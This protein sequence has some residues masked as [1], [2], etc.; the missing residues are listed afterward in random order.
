MRLLFWV[1]CIG[2]LFSSC[3]PDNVPQGLKATPNAVGDLNQLVII[4][5]EDVW[6]G[7]VGD[8]LR[9]YYTSAFPILPQ[10]EP[11]F[12]VLHFTALELQ[13]E[14]LRKELRN[15]LVVA[16]LEDEQSPT[17]RLVR[18]DLGPEK[19]RKAKEDPGYFSTVGKD[20]WARGQV[21]IYQFAYGQDNLIQKLTRAFPA[22]VKRLNKADQKKLEAT[23]Y[24]DDQS[25]KL[26]QE[27]KDIIG[28]D[29]RIPGD[30]FKA[31]SDENTIWIRKETENVSSN[32]FF[33]RME[34]KDQ[35]QISKDGIKS[36]RDSLG[37]LVSTQIPN[38]YMKINDVDL[39]ML[40]QQTTIN[41]N[42]ALEARGIWEIE[43]DFMG[44]PFVS[45]LILDQEDNALIF[46]DGFIHAPGEDKRNFIQY[47]EHI[48]QTVKV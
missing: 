35:E 23:V 24:L 6:K 45:Y 12:D 5:D 3:G 13:E 20:K 47:L 21:V 29:A 19:M 32:L 27:I 44:G 48:I 10:P 4:A 40:T 25:P 17:A 39:P 8:T 46:V 28:I 31:Y 1:P 9:F 11:M 36:V 43:N 22:T 38:T 16:N 34:Y 7:P 41:G 2:L 42:Y 26:E 15:Y 30:Y 18:N 37:R 33:K 14:K